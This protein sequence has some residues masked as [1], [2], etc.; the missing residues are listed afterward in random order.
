MGGLAPDDER[1]MEPATARYVQGAWRAVEARTGAR[2][3]H[4]FWEHHTPRRSTWPACRAVLAAGGRGREMFAAIQRAYY[5]DARDPS[6]RS[7]LVS[8]AGELGFDEPGFERSIDSDE[9]R[10]AL[11][12]D[13]DLR[14]LVGA[15]GFPSLGLVRDGRTRLLTRGWVD[16]AAATKVL[17]SAGLI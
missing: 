9:T 1:P 2:F 7:T 13:F 15:T 4:A 6:D 14:D 3:E 5:L 17:S 8:I 11:M 16:L 12:R 10:H